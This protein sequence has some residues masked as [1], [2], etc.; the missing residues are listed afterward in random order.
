MYAMFL[1][2][3]VVFFQSLNTM[4]TAC[5]RFTNRVS[6]QLNLNDLH[7]VTSI[8]QWSSHHVDNLKRL[9][10]ERAEAN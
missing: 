5:R 8:L 6:V 4:D 9:E 2:W 10:L 1:D 7:I 3:S